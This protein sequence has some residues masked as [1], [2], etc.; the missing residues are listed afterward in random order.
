MSANALGS[1]LASNLR[2]TT[3]TMRIFIDRGSIRIHDAIGIPASSTSLL[4][5]LT[6]VADDVSSPVALRTPPVRG[7]DRV[8]LTNPL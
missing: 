8:H 3:S 5:A 1:A 7:K 6:I 4:Q 2:I